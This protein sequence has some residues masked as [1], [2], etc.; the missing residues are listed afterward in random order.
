MVVLGGALPGAPFI[1]GIGRATVA[2]A[3]ESRNELHKPSGWMPPGLG[4]ALVRDRPP[5]GWRPPKRC[6][7]D[8]FECV[9]A[10]ACKV[11]QERVATRHPTALSSFR[12]D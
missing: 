5:I 11:G 10:S 1:S 3:A 8:A 7:Q 12:A 2:T 4:S 9:T 6:A